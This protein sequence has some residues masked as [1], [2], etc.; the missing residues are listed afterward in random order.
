[1]AEGILT[2]FPDLS[3]VTQT[4]GSIESGLRGLVSIFGNITQENPNSPLAGVGNA[5]QGLSSTLSID[6][7]GLTQRFPSALQNVSHAL[8]P[9][10]L[11]FVNSISGGYGSAR[12][13]LAGN[14]I[15]QAVGRDK[16]VQD[17]AL[18]VVGDVLH[19]FD[20]QWGTL[21]NHLVDAD[22]LSAVKDTFNQIQL[23]QTDFNAHKSDLLPFLSKNL[24][25]VASDVL[26]TPIHHANDA[27]A[28]LNPL[29]AAAI[30]TAIGTELRAALTVFN[31]LSTAV[32][33]MDGTD[34]AVYAR[35]NAFLDSAA[36]AVPAV[37][38]AMTPLYAGAQRVVE[39]HAWDTLFSAHRTAL[40]AV[41]IGTSFSVDSVVQEMAA[42]LD[43]IFARLQAV[44]GPDDLVQRIQSLSQTIQDTVATSPLGQV[45][46]TIRDFLE[47]IKTIIEGI[48]TEQIQKVV[49]DMLGRVRQEIESLGLT[50]IAET[51]ENGFKSV[52]EFINGHI[53]ND[54]KDQISSAIHALS[55]ALDRLPIQTLVDNINQLVAQLNGL[56]EEAEN[57][58]KQAFD[59]ISA[60]LAKLDEL[61]FKP[62]SDPVIAEINVLKGKLQQINPNALSNLEKLALSA[63]LAVL[64]QIDLEGMIENEIKKGFGVAKDAVLHLLD[65]VTAVLKALRDRVRG[66]QPD[67]LAKTVTSGLDQVKK[68]VE[69]LSAKTLMKPLYDKVEDLRK[70]L[71]SL[72]PGSLLDPLEQPYKVIRSAVDK[73]NPDQIVEPVKSIYAE[74]NHL[75]DYVDITPLLN[76]LDR[77]QKDLFKRVRDSILSALDGLSLPGPLGEFFH[78][79]KPAL[80]AMTDAIF[81][82]PDTEMRR[83]TLDLSGRF[84]LSTLLA[85]LDKVF[86][87]LM[88]MIA[89]VPE[90][91]LVQAMNAIRTGIGVGLDVIDPWKIMSALRAG[92]SQ[93][94][95]I[96][97]A[98]LLSMPLHLP[99]IQAQFELK[100]AGVPASLQPS[101]DGTRAKF[102]GVL[103]LLDRADP[104]SLIAPL[105][106]AHESLENALATHINA[107]DPMPAEAAYAKLRQNLDQLLPDFLRQRTALTYKDIMNGFGSLRPSQKTGPIDGLFNKFLEH[108]KPIQAA[109]EPAINGFFKAI[110][111]TLMLLNPLSLKDAVADIYTAIRKKVEILDPVKLAAELHSSIFDP[112]VNALAAIDPA[113]IKQRLDTAFQSALNTLTARVKDI[114]D[115]IAAVLDAEMK[116]IAA[117]VASIINNIE[118]AMADAVKLF[119]D[120]MDRVDKLV[121]T[122]IL[123]RLR[124]VVE[125]LASSFNTELDRVRSAFDEMLNAIPLG[126]GSQRVSGAVSA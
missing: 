58:L 35:L 63:A 28:V 15:L 54:L 3:N 62:V 27:L 45:R 61:S 74:V 105:I 81:Q 91:D 72:S 64:R 37:T 107:L 8:P 13:F 1:M 112:V 18:G 114:L 57:A 41:S 125:K 99:A 4:R 113:A 106:T 43:A 67:Q 17:A 21:T 59:K 10:A 96:S 19:A 120:I 22:T 46:K 2:R 24:L 16:S 12:D 26:Q 47:K 65:Q 79:M 32:A 6:T 30:Q 87:Q 95:A 102:T 53:N 70:Q 44:L 49:D 42:T 73:L 39:S 38:T 119:H 51:I 115:Q 85:P 11:D 76:E 23:F 36:A 77:R 94:A 97:P 33:K 50:H 66:F 80:E 121:F 100:V 123:D 111:D 108:L 118:Q 48:P 34:A 101:L 126:G 20:Q 109:L 14:P 25:G 9:S 110:R 98:K 103:K 122:E 90:A 89:S 52:E 124:K 60:T 71:G 31:D 75:I 88:Q 92:Q 69:A 84:Q 86:D 78:A 56:I 7:S 116:K 29:D 83:M 93:L 104:G 55:D 82:D 5:I 117:A 68:A 40:E